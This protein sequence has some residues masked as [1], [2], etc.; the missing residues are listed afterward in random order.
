MKVSLS[1][2]K[3]KKAGNNKDKDV[4]ALLSEWIGPQTSKEQVQVEDYGE[5]KGAELGDNRPIEPKST[6]FKGQSIVKWIFF[7][8]FIAYMVISYYRVPILTALGNYLILEHPLKKADLIVC[9]PGNPFE[10]S[11][12]AAEI[13]KRGLAPRIFIPKETPPDGLETLK[14]QGGRYPE[15]SGLFIGALKSLNVPE[16]AFLTGKLAVDSIREEAEEVREVVI[17]ESYGS[18]I[19]V[20]SPSRARRTY[21]IF[22]KVFE[23]EKLEIMISPSRYS[24]L[25]ADNWWQRDKYLNEVVF[26][27]QKVLYHTIKNLW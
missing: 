7:I 16:S 6:R 27:R 8:L 2:L 22:E 3:M 20:T 17:N 25:K 21:L 9:T 26:E 11:L 14:A 10:Q 15:T 23:G 24:D 12:M 5:T 19:I 18:I 1:S 13:Y 4:A